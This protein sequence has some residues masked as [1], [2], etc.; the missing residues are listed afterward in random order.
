[1]K[2]LF[3][4]LFFLLLN[5]TENYCLYKADKLCCKTC[6]NSFYTTHPFISPFSAAN[7][8]LQN[9][10]K[11]LVSK[12]AKI[13]PLDSEPYVSAIIGSHKLLFPPDSLCIYMLRQLLFNN[14]EILLYFLIAK[15]CDCDP[16]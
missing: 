8:I 11:K 9:G 16:R 14:G 5:E 1:M 3:F 7:S 6:L 13:V 15:I 12:L 2:S 4:L 10:R